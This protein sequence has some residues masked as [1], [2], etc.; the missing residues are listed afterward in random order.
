MHPDAK[1]KLKKLGP[2]LDF[3]TPAKC[4]VNDNNPFGK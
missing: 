4:N 2:Q 3:V 1:G